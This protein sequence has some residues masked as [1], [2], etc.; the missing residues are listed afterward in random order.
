MSYH[1]ILIMPYHFFFLLILSA[2]AVDYSSGESRSSTLSIQI[3]NMMKKGDKI[4]EYHYLFGVFLKNLGIQLNVL[5][6][7]VVHS[8]PTASKSQPHQYQPRQT[9]LFQS[10]PPFQT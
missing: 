7:K 1:L 6:L 2:S 10:A 9:S 4:D 5:E 3:S 8:W